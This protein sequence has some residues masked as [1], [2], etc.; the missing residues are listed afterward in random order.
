VT[1]YGLDGPRIGFWWGKISCTHPDR[2]YRRTR[3]KIKRK[4]KKKRKKTKISLHG[5]PLQYWAL[6]L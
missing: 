6:F 2:L 1:C 3:R 4:R 5:K